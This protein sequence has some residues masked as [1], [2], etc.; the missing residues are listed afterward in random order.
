VTKVSLKDWQGNG[1]LREHQAS[2]EEITDLFA[3]ADRDL[4][5]S[6]TRGPHDDWRFNIAYNAALQ[7]ATA[8]LAAS[9][10]QAERAAHHYRIIQ[11]RE[12]TIGM[13]AKSVRKL[14]IFR[15]K[16]NVSDY[17]RADTVS[18][19][20]VE[21]MRKLAAWLRTEIEAWLAKNHPALKR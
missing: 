19:L 18:E 2:L 13:D 14:D 8:A 10:Y 6:N 3:I 20:E 7:L 15:K 17:D 12:F 21:E 5:A 16:R 11:S 4:K 9:G 1:W